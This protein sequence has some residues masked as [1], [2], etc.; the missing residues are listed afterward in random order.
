MGPGGD[1]GETKR[2]GGTTA[3]VWRGDQSWHRR[4]GAVDGRDTSGHDGR[5]AGRSAELGCDAERHHLRRGWADARG[6]RGVGSGRR[7]D[8]HHD[9]LHRYPRPLPLSTARQWHLPRLGAGRGVRDG[10]SRADRGR[11]A[12]HPPRADPDDDRRLHLAAQRRGMARLAAG[13]D[14][15]GSA[16]EGD[17]SR[18]LHGVPFPQRGVTQPVRRAGLA[19]DPRHDGAVDVHRLAR[20]H[21]TPARQLRG[22][23]RHLSGSHHPV[24]QGGAGGLSGQGSGAR[25]G[26]RVQAPAA[27]DR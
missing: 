11:G 16:D 22:R 4:A 21:A 25:V 26:A 6:R 9:G 18:Q 15:R 12:T 19:G 8:V 24:P 27:S 14:V 1:R 5:G 2:N 10:A 17:L 3:R 13:G 20:R 23:R 7:Q